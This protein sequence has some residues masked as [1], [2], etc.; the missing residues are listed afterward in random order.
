VKII[1]DFEKLTRKAIEE[2]VKVKIRGRV[3]NIQIYKDKHG[4]EHN[5]NIHHLAMYT[6]PCDT[7]I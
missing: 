3:N 1:V 7:L 5:K 2:I 4:H 6:C